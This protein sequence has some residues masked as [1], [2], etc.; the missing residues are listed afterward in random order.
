M[1]YSAAQ[2]FNARMT[3]NGA[4]IRAAER[5]PT[6]DLLNLVTAV[7][8]IAF[9]E[10]YLAGKVIEAFT[11]QEKKKRSHS[12]VGFLSLLKVVTSMF[13]Y[14]NVYDTLANA[15]NKCVDA[16]SDKR[17]ENDLDFEILQS[18]RVIEYSEFV[19]VCGEYVYNSDN[20]RDL[21]RRPDVRELRVMEKDGEIVALEEVILEKL[22]VEKHVKLNVEKTADINVDLHD[23]T[24]DYQVNGMLGRMPDGREQ[25]SV[26]YK[27]KTSSNGKLNRLRRNMVG[28]AYRK[29]KSDSLSDIDAKRI[30][31]IR[32]E[33]IVE[34]S[35]G[36]L[37]RMNGDGHCLFHALAYFTEYDAMSMRFVVAS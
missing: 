37:V 21:I 6:L 36:T 27:L 4:D 18:V 8:C 19:R 24:L 10:R 23:V 26:I 33:G 7:Y 25:G 20:G 32:N 29:M 28:R 34:C 5:I 11:T 14:G 22:G 35:V 13:K 12:R 9:R 3:I 31:R 30:G 2:S 15:W 1:M 16:L 17:S